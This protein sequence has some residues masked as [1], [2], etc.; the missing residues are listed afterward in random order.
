MANLTKITLPD[1][2]TY[3]FK[4]DVSGYS[5]VSVN[6]KTTSGTNIADI[7]IDGATTQ[8]YAPS[9]GGSVEKNTW[10]GTSATASTTQTKDVTTSTGDF[11]LTTGNM[12]RV[13]F[14]YAQAYEGAPILNVDGTGAKNVTLGS[15]TVPS[16]IWNGGEVVDFVYDGTRFVMVR[17][18]LATTTFYGLTKLSSAVNSTQTN[19][20]ATPRAVKYAY[21][22]A[23]DKQDP[24]VSG[25][26]I[27]TI[28]NESI[29]GSGNITITSGAQVYYG[30]TEPSSSLGNDG[31]LYVLL[32]E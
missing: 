9:G 31:D 18:G 5:T 29:L 7:T 28:N 27:K 2:N 21:D 32:E 8:L 4:D 15:T 25:I 17:S 30:T 10:Y 6:R 26:N 14:T 12:V 13:K 20:A 3:D 22:L 23:N 24:L 16:Y 19:I 1:G 11:T